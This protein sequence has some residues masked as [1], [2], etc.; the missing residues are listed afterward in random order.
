MLSL[1]VLSQGALVV[2][3]G[4]AAVGAHIGS[5]LDV[6]VHHV[7][8]NFVP[9]DEAFPAQFAVVGLLGVAP[10]HD[11]FVRRKLLLV[12]AHGCAL[13]SVRKKLP[14]LPSLEKKV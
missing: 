13:Q 11:Q 14:T 5:G 8:V 6:D 1:F 10:V 7:D 3:G 4:T 12:L 2:V 9:R